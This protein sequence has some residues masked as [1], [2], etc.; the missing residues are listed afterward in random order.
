MRTCVRA[1]MYEVHHMPGTIYKL[2]FL[3]CKHLKDVDINNLCGIPKD[4]KCSQVNIIPNAF[5]RNAITYVHVYLVCSTIVKYK[6]WNLYLS[7][8]W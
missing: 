4:V 2:L 8:M 5:S 3:V 1:Y 7:F 6:Q